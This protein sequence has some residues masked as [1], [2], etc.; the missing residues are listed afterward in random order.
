MA[1]IEQSPYAGTWKA[2]AR[3]VVKVTPDALIFINGDLTIPGCPT[4]RGRLEIQKYVTGFSVE[5]GT[6]ATSHSASINLSLPRMSGEQFFVDGKHKL[7]PG[8]EINIFMRGYFPVRGQFAHLVEEDDDD[9]NLA[10]LAAYPYYPVFHGVTTTSSYQYSDG[11]YNGTIQCSSLLHFWQYVNISS[12][13]A[14][15]GVKPTND[16]ARPTFFGHVFNNMHPFGIMYTLYRD[17]AGSAAGIEFALSGQSNVDASMLGVAAAAQDGGRQIYDQ[18]ALYWEQRW[19]TRVQNLRMYGVNGQLF[20]GAQQAYFASASNRDLQGTLSSTQYADPSNQ[21]T[22]VD[23]FSQKQSVAKALG[24]G[25]GGTDQ[26]FTTI[27]GEEGDPISIN[28]L[29]LFAFTQGIGEIGT[30]NLWETTYQTKIDVAQ[31]VTEVTGFEFYQDVDGDLVFKPPFYNLDTSS[32]RYYRLEDI[33]IMSIDFQEKEPTATYIN[34]RGTWFKGLTDVVSNTEATAKRSVYVDYKLVST[35]GWRQASWDVTFT[36]DPRVLFY[37]GMSRLDLLNIDVNS[38]TATIPY[39]PEM[40]PGYPVYIPFVDCYYYVS[41]LS[42]SFSFGGQCTTSLTLTCRRAKFEAPGFLEAPAPGESAISKIRLDRPDLPNRSLQALIGGI[43]RKVGFPNVV[44]ALDPTKAS[45]SFFPVGAGLDYLN[46]T[47]DVELLFNFIRQDIATLTPQILQVAPSLEGDGAQ[48]PTSE[49]RYRLQMGPDGFAEFGLAELVAGFTDLQAVRGGLRDLESQIASKRNEISAAIQRENV[50]AA[51]PSSPDRGIAENELLQLQA[52][53][54][55]EQARL[56]QPGSSR[57]VLIQVVEAL[58]TGRGGSMRRRVDGIPGSD[59]TASY[60]DTLQ[61]LKGQYMT[62]TLPGRYRYYSSAHPF[63][64]MQGQPLI[65]FD[66]GERPAEVVGGTSSL[67]PPVIQSP[68]A[69]PAGLGSLTDRMQGVLDSQ[70]ITWISVDKPYSVVA[71]GKSRPANALLGKSGKAVANNEAFLDEYVGENL[72][73]IALVA[74]TV[75]TGALANPAWPVGY[76]IIA[77]STFRPSEGAKAEAMHGE[78]L[79]MDLII[80]GSGDYIGATGKANAPVE[81]VTAFGILRGEAVRAMSEGTITG[82]GTYEAS[83]GGGW[84]VHIDRRSTDALA[85]AFERKKALAEANG[86]PE[87]KQRNVPGRDFWFEDSG[88]RLKDAAR[89]AALAEL[90]A[91]AQALGISWPPRARKNPVSVFAGFAKPGGALPPAPPSTPQQITK[92]EPLG[93]VPLIT[94]RELQVTARPVVQFLEV[95]TKEEGQRAPEV[96]IG[97]G[98]CERGLNIAQ[99]PGRPPK[100][101]TTDQIQTLSFAQFG[102]ANFTSVIGAPT[103]G[104]KATLSQPELLTQLVLV[105]TQALQNLVDPTQTPE[106]FLGPLYTQVSENLKALVVPQ[107]EGG[108]LRDSVPLQLP[109]FAEAVP[110]VAIPPGLEGV[111]EGNVVPIHKNSIE[112]LSQVPGYTS[113]RARTADAQNYQPT[114]DRVVSAYAQ[115]VVGVVVTGFTSAQTAAEAPPQDRENRLSQVQSAFDPIIRA[116][117]GSDSIPWVSAVPS[118][119]VGKTGKTTKAIHSPVFPVSDEQGYEH[120]GAYRYGRG[121]TIDPGGSF[122]FVHQNADPFRNVSAAAIEE[123]LQTLTLVKGR[124]GGAVGGGQLASIREAASSALKATLEVAGE[125]LMGPTLGAEVPAEIRRKQSDIEQTLTDVNTVAKELSRTPQGQE[126]LRELLTAN[127]DPNVITQDGWDLSNTQFQRNFANFAATYAM[128]APFKT[129]IGNAAYQLSDI[130]SKLLSGS[131]GV[132]RCRGDMADV[133]LAA[134]GR[135]D[136]VSLDT[137]DA[138]AAFTADAIARAAGPY[139]QE[140]QGMRGETQDVNRPD[141]QHFDSV[142]KA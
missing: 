15:L 131:Q 89:K 123:F 94:T 85:R 90:A 24:L 32:S 14:H 98:S 120:F 49:T 62:T 139:R 104:G 92:V 134:Y 16:P 10:N 135:E 2:N 142:Y 55:D 8:L 121:L 29:D 57:A 21:R 34:V 116:I 6:E 30:V 27:V 133:T 33:D 88:V 75:R 17:V 108:I 122:E 65:L 117:V 41:Q 31:Q 1:T 87:P 97:V 76:Q 81:L 61:H 18:V 42:H 46:S 99:G 72:V 79:A 109:A 38:A 5:A 56:A 115:I 136:F 86:L 96:V 20:N 13:M 130:T 25:A 91:D 107:F 73:N 82:M 59:V 102:T 51:A 35:F 140:V 12:S 45:P 125:V 67:V 119:K 74:N 111:F 48:V 3:A 112:A 60:F 64:E 4:C 28:L 141:A 138:V 70:G 47:Q 23:P 53:L 93:Q 132:C 127:G 113:P 7:K 71:F 63:P 118:T 80:A 50:F 36:T 43:P 39:R 9:I 44:L 69:A 129:T 66:E 52:R 105:W 110:S 114:I 100:V 124:S 83:G 137:D 95:V 22:E 54:T 78:G 11:F 84:F 128:E 126:T 19:K 101:L 77:L 103:E 106:E 26:T 68:V 37:L 58:R 40:R